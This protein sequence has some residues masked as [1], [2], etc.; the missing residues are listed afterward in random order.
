MSLSELRVL[1][2]YERLWRENR[3]LLALLRAG[4]SLAEAEGA[5]R[6]GPQPPP[7]RKDEG[8]R[9]CPERSEGMKD[10]ASLFILSTSSFHEGHPRRG[11]R[12]IV[13]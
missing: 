10:E 11:V 6:D 7:L 4:Y 9:A 5:L 2:L 12:R 1:A 13:V 3:L 8:G